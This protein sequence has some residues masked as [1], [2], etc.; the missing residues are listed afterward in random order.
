MWL[1][2]IFRDFGKRITTI[3]EWV[4]NLDLKSS[5]EKKI[6][7]SSAKVEALIEKS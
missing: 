7:K 2:E 1:L 3:K 6:K 4:C 5:L